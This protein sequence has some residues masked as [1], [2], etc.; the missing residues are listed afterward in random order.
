MQK[1]AASKKTFWALVDRNHP[2]GCWMWQG[3]RHQQYGVTSWQG[4]RWR[5]HRLAY[6]LLWG[7]IPTGYHLD[8]LCRNTLCVYPWHLEPVT[9]AENSRRNVVSMKLNPPKRGKRKEDQRTEWYDSWLRSFKPV[10]VTN[11]RS[12]DDNN[13]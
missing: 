13:P 6:T 9:P 4:K 7:D 10:F 1:M 8:H 3:Q 12:P 11:V 5:A 2:S